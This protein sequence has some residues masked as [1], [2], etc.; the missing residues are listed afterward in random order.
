MDE[1][2]QFYP[3]QR[4]VEVTRTEQGVMRWF[5]VYDPKRLGRWREWRPVLKGRFV[6]NVSVT[7]RGH[8]RWLV[9][10]DGVKSIFRPNRSEAF[11]DGRDFVME[12]LATTPPQED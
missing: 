1:Y 11:W 6:P 3:G 7:R 2:I 9:C 8:G 5:E 12:T 10:L 4:G